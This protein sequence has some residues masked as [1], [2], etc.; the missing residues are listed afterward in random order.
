MAIS[1]ARKPL[2]AVTGLGRLLTPSMASL[3]LSLGLALALVIIHVLFTNIRSGNLWSSADNGYLA[4]DFNSYLAQPLIRIFQ[5]DFAARAGT[6]FLWSL[7]GGAIYAVGEYLVASAIQWYKTETSLEV[8][9]NR[10]VFHPR[11]KALLITAAWRF[12]VGI[13]VVTSFYLLLP[14][15]RYAFGL[16]HHLTAGHFAVA[17]LIWFAVFNVSIILMRLYSMRVRLFGVSLK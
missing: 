8:L 2:S 14:A 15:F 10:L 6:I 3:S 5:S 13:I 9:N 12:V 11:Q 17:V 1:A 16:D 7:V 4:A